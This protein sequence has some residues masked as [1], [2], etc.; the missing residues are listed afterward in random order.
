MPAVCGF[1]SGSR[2]PPV[3]L[4]TLK[5]QRHVGGLSFPY[6]SRLIFQPSLLFLRINQL[7]FGHK[8]LLI[9]CICLLFSLK[10]VRDAVTQQESRTGWGLNWPAQSHFNVTGKLIQR[11][12]MTCLRSHRDS[13][14]QVP[15][16]VS[17]TDIV[18][19]SGEGLSLWHQIAWAQLPS[20][21]NHVPLEQVTENHSE[22]QACHMRDK[23]QKGLRTAP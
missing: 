12:E 6:L 4:M 16:S 3:G 18:Q 9:E 17:C 8:Q 15:G 20:F 11:G 10:H 7:L 21:P 1:P 13:H 14:A 5:T 22:L 23:T 19:D 2:K